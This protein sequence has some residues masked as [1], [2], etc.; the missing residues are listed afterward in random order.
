MP[1]RRQTIRHLF[2]GGAAT[3]YG[4]NAEVL[5]REDGVVV[6]PFLVEA[7]NIVYELDGG[8]HKIGGTTK[9]NST[10]VPS[11]EQ[12]LGLFDY[13]NQVTPTQKRVIKAGTVVYK[14]DA[15]GTWDSHIT[16][17]TDDAVPCFTTFDDL[18]IYS[19]TGGKVPRK[20]STGAQ[21]NLGTDTPV[22]AFSVAHKN[23]LWAAGVTGAD[24]NSK[25]YYSPLE[26]P[27]GTWEAGDSGSISVDF[28]DGDRITGLASHKNDLWVFKGPY[29]GSI[30]RITGS[31]P[32]GSDGFA[33]QTF[34]RGLGA[35][36]HNSIFRFKDDLG[37][38]WSDGSIHSLAATAAFGDFNET[39]LSRPINGWLRDRGNHDRLDHAW[40]AGDVSRGIV[41]FTIAIDT[42]TDNNMTLLMDYRFDPV[43][44][45]F[46]PSYKL[47]SVASVIDPGNNNLPTLMGGGNDGFVRKLFQANRSLDPNEA[48][49]A[50]VHTPF[51]SYGSPMRRKT[52]AYASLG[53]RPRGNYATTFKWQR[54]QENVQSVDLTQGGGDVLGPA[55]ANAFTLDSSVLGGS[56]FLDRYAD[57]QEGGEFSSIQYQLEQ[58]GD[59][60]D[61]EVHSIST[62]I[63]FGA[64]SVEE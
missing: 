64:D 34:V 20:F 41:L 55:D 43:R 11:S 19:E 26:D 57:L 6:L 47:G 8:V 63:E 53:M 10:V 25:V 4:P 3:D 56:I 62:T 44:W 16:G 48:I 60:Q 21:S 13:W 17:L 29:H 40:A 51:I 28:G 42:S 52:I 37:F 46:L 23:R 38:M 49:P 39:S 18:C 12:V 9:V 32:T 2:G 61:M 33:R 50:K 14:D 22:F 30:H 5:V 36:N 1:T 54:D 15:D 58:L 45:A 35:V 24:D 7:E 31:S 59:N 27:D